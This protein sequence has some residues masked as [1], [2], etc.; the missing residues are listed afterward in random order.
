M[1]NTVYSKSNSKLFE[2]IHSFCQAEGSVSFPYNKETQEKI[3]NYCVGNSQKDDEGHFVNLSSRFSDTIKSLKGFVCYDKQKTR[4]NFDTIFLTETDPMKA[5]E[6]CLS[7]KKDYCALLNLLSRRKNISRTRLHKEYAKFLDIDMKMPSE[8]NT[9]NSNISLF[10]NQNKIVQIKDM[11]FVKDVASN[12]GNFCE[13]KTIIE[14]C[15]GKKKENIF[16]KEISKDYESLFKPLGIEKKNIGYDLVLKENGFI[17]GI[18]IKSSHKNAHLNSKQELLQNLSSFEE[19]NIEEKTHK[20]FSLGQ[21]KRI[22]NILAISHGTEKKILHNRVFTYQKTDYLDIEDF[23]NFLKEKQTSAKLNS[24][25][26]QFKWDS[27]SLTVDGLEIIFLDKDATRGF[28]ININNLCHI[29]KD[30]FKPYL[31]E[32]KVEN[33]KTISIKSSEYLKTHS[34]SIVNQIV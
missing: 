10:K 34:T 15:D 7:R 18:S 14:L 12:F 1:K 21:H 11:L 29:F 8:I 6:A 19:M 9:F 17:Y 23:I 4:I 22:K 30:K 27:E 3:V 25:E 33:E 24:E 13:N 31:F 32:Q 2:Q 26:H 28:K 16:L 20:L 5:V